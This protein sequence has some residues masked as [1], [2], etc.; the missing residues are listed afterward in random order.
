MR[1]GGA[2]FGAVVG[3]ARQGKRS[4]RVAESKRAGAPATTP[5]GV[6][7]N[8]SKVRRCSLSPLSVPRAES[9]RRESATRIRSSLVVPHLV[10]ALLVDPFVRFIVRSLVIFL[11]V[12]K[13]GNRSRDRTR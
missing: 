7:V 5:V 4:T 1:R 11:R 8:P 13:T 9:E 10:R 12:A 6:A 2:Q 3:S